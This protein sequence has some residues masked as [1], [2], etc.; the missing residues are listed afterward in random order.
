MPSGRPTIASY[1]ATFLPREMLHVYRQVCGV[2]SFDHWVM[3]RRRANAAAFPFPQVIELRKSP[4]RVFNRLWHRAFSDCVPVARF[5]IAQMLRSCQD[6]DVSL[7]HIYLGTEGLRIFSFLNQFRGARVISFHGADLSDEFDAESYAPL[8]NH[9]EL[10]LCRSQSLRAQLLVKGC[11][12]DRVR[13]NYTGVPVPSEFAGRRLPDWHKKEPVRLLQACRFIQKKGLDAT[14]RAI[15]LLKDKAI[16]VSLTLAGEGP[17][18]S[19]LRALAREL[20]IADQVVFTGFL[21]REQLEEAYRRHHL[22]VHPSR[23]TP[24]GDREGIPNSVLEA[25]AY[26]LPVVS[27]RH[28]GIPEAITDGQDGLL[29]ERP[30]PSTLAAAVRHLIENPSLYERLSSNAHDTVLKRFSL[31]ANAAALE[32]L[33]HEALSLHPATGH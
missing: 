1:C 14:L 23:T 27:T 15:R 28:S 12:A 10:F 32:A 18:E 7:V 21:A 13:L 25:M 17:E 8:W 6:R 3:T 22:F 4:W 19:S 9:A 20:D 33:Y 16:P 2:R 5:E 24:E 11:P 30:D 26:G 31:A 29:V